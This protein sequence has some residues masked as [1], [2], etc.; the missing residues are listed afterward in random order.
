MHHSAGSAIVGLSALGFWAAKERCR[1]VVRESLAHLRSTAPI[2]PDASMLHRFL[3]RQ[4]RR[5]CTRCKRS[6]PQHGRDTRRL[7][8]EY[9]M[10]G[11]PMR[12]QVVVMGATGNETRWGQNPRWRPRLIHGARHQWIWV[13]AATTNTSTR[14][15]QDKAALAGLEPCSLP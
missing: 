10:K 14:S 15:T 5:R 1:C 4:M 13:I 2:A 3:L 6:R 11:A 8:D 12:Y 9:L 7:A